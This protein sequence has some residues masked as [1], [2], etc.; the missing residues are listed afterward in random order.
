M[1]KTI[2]GVIG[3]LASVCL[4]IG[5]F[6]GC[7][8]ADSKPQNSKQTVSTDGST[9]MEKV[10]GYLSESYMADNSDI[11]VTYNPTGS[12]CCRRQM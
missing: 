11:T 9:S 7:K 6:A 2:I 8:G 3:V 12:G 4:I 1:K 10:I 5:I